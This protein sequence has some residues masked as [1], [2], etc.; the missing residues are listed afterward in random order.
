M[1]RGHRP[2]LQCVGP[3]DIV[4]PQLSVNETTKLP[5]SGEKRMS[6]RSTPLSSDV[7]REAGDR[8]PRAREAA[9]F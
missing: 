9:I 1:A 7:S 4:I 8:E 6:E 3:R 2:R 5:C